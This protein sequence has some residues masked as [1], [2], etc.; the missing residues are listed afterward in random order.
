MSGA[1]RLAS[2]AR[3]AVCTIRE[4]LPVSATIFSASARMEI[5][6]LLPRFTVRT[7]PA[8]GGVSISLTSP[9]TRSSTQQNVRSCSPLP[10]TT[11]SRFCK[12]ATT[13][14]ITTR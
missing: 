11:M 6:W 8:D 2:S 10:L 14:F 12:A 1:R 3:A 5:S 13:I 9:S 7:A 4:R